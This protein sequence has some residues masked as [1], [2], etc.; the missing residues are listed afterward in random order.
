MADVV[1][2]S[3][4]PAETITRPWTNVAFYDVAAGET[5]KPAVPGLAERDAR[6][7]AT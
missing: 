7:L 4:R 2:C 3:R 1:K 5:G 6:V